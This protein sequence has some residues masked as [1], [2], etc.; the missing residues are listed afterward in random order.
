MR[1]KCRTQI[2]TGGR[3]M[4]KRRITALFLCAILLMGLAV[5]AWG[6]EADENGFIIEA[7]ILTGYTGGEA[8]IQIPEGVTSIADRV[9][10]QQHNYIRYPAL[11]AGNDW[12]WCLFWS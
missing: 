12:D 10:E 7:G 3:F 4:M 2:K 6:V 1:L 8:E 5:P 9:L 11:D